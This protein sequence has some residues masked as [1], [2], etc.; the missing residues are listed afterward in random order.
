[1]EA[2]G[3][4]PLDPLQM[5]LNYIMRID[6]SIEPLPGLLARV[7]ALTESTRQLEMSVREQNRESTE[8]GRAVDG[9]NL[10]VSE[11]LAAMTAIGSDLR[12]FKQQVNGRLVALERQAQA[13]LDGVSVQN[14]TLRQL[15]ARVDAVEDRQ[16]DPEFRTR[17]E[18]CASEFTAARPVL[19]QVAAIVAEMAEIRPWFKGLKWFAAIMGAVFVTALAVAILWLLAQ[20][21]AGLP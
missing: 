5:I 13:A 15:T 8:R 10:R 11:V 21:G 16:G 18:A 1:M 20:S 3:T 7:E 6:R 14:A 17:L 4:Q 19:A 9:L 2:K 12:E